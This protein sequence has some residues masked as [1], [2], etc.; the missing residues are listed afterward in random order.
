MMGA[1]NR[2]VRNASYDVTQLEGEF[3]VVLGKTDF[4]LG[5]LFCTSWHSVTG[6]KGV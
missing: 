2:H 1:K 6:S 5:V 3:K 4:V